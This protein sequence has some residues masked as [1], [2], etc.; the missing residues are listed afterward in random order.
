MS[1]H[2]YDIMSK[3]NLNLTNLV[4]PKNYSWKAKNSTNPSFATEI[5]KISSCSPLIESTI[6]VTNLTLPSLLTYTNGIAEFWLSGLEH[7]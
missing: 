5:A 1:T 4:I 2:L 3:H 6:S 7:D